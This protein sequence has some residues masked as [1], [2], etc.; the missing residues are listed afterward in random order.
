MESL[1]RWPYKWWLPGVITWVFPKIGGK[2]TKWMVKIMETPLKMDDLGGK[3]LF[4]VETSISIRKP[5][6]SLPF[7]TGRD[8]LCT[9]DATSTV[10][11]GLGWGASRLGWGRGVGIT[12]GQGTRTGVPLTYVYP[13]YLAGVLGWDS[14]CSWGREILYF[15]EI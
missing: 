5:R 9:L 8:P 3:P 12:D 11:L 2:T 6:V 4:F 14:T 10:L 1:Y 15:S 13:W 7:L